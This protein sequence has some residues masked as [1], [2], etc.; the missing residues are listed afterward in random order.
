MPHLA[1]IAV[2]AFLHIWPNDTRPCERVSLDF[3]ANLQRCVEWA[4][5]ARGSGAR[6]FC[7]QTRD[8]E[9]VI[10][11]ALLHAG[12]PG[13]QSTTWGFVPMIKAHEKHFRPGDHLCIWRAE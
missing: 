2:T 10:F 4:D 11:F 7:T 13:V 8:G 3:G 1:A 9:E 6:A 12:R 5:R